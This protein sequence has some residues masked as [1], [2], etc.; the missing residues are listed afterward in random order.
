[1]YI[2]SYNILTLAF[3]N[4]FADRDMFMRYTHLGV[5]HPVM[6]RRII[7][8]CESL[9]LPNAMDVVDKEVSDGEDQEEVNDEHLGGDD[10]QEENDDEF[11]DEEPEDD[12]EEEE[13][14][15]NDEGGDNIED[16]FD[17]LS[18]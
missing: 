9:T 16:L 3:C 11:S 5:G 2:S 10:E 13:D 14:G 18:F 6:I 7:R 12:E 17:D 8:D 4:R 1:M 15:E